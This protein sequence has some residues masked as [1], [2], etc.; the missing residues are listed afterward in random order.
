MAQRPDLSGDCAPGREWIVRRRTTPFIQPH[1]L[2]QVLGQ[3]LG[4]CE[5][6]AFARRDEQV[7]VRREQETMAVVARIAGVARPVLTEG[8]RGVR[9]ARRVLAGRGLVEAITWSFIDKSA[10][11]AFGGGQDSLEIANPIS[12]EMNSMRP[13]LLPGL[14]STVLRN[15]NRGFADA[16][17]FEVGQCYRGDAPGDQFIAASAVRAGAIDIAGSGRHWDGTPADAGLFQAKSDAFA[18]L[19]NLGFET[20]KAQVSREVPAWFHPG[21]SAVLKLGPK[22]TLAQF[23]EVHP[24][25]LEAMGL[26]GPVAACEVFLDALPSKRKTAG[27]GLLEGLT[28]L[29]VTRDFAFVVDAQVSSAEIVRAAAAADKVLISHVGVFDVFE[30]ESVGKG[31]KSLA[32][33]VTIQPREKTLTDAEIDAVAERVIAQVEKA[34]GAK[35]RS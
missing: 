1:D 31:K 29:P 24:R 14:L 25:V 21:R 10:A 8:Q 33:E 17:F 28:L 23:G 35:I 7:T 30:D 22:T 3:V 12:S 27:R 32:L 2:P 20:P 15:R 5:F 34:T 9:R 6:L 18:V 26:T 11:T 4:G 19:S 13:S 16:G